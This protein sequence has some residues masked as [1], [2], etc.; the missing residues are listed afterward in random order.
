MMRSAY[1]L[2]ADDDDW[3]QAGTL[4]RDVMDDA[5]RER[6]VSNVVGHLR[7]GVS[8]R[9][10]Q[11]AVE[12]WQSIDKQVGDQIEIAVRNGTSETIDG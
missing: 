10:L 6:M 8:E 11:R 9:V 3:R 5:A 7:N 1:T 4:V 2:R 12:Y